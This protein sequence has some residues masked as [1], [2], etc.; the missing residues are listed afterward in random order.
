MTQLRAF[1]VDDEPL[2]LRRLIL[3]LGDIENVEIVGSSTSAK[4]AIGLIQKL[5]P[6]VV[7]LD[8]AMPSLDGFQVLERLDPAPAVVFVTAYDAH[9][10]R[11]FGVDAVDYLMKPV[12]P[13][14]LRRAVDRVRIAVEARTSASAMAAGDALPLPPGIDSPS[15]EE[16]LWA[17]R[18]REIVRVPVETI[19][20]IEAERD[21]VRLHSQEGGGLLRTTLAG[22]EAN[23]DPSL[24]IRVHRSAI[25]R[26]SAVTSLRRK[27]S[28]AL[29][30]SLAD[31]SEVPVG[32]R[33]ARGLRELLQQIR[34]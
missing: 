10:V 21:Y 9:A 20:W 23:L 3:T 26:R 19:E 32:R 29:V 27:R 30:I 2:A 17:Q 14:R 31:G 13:A 25:C 6:D 8:I 33:Y 15:Y 1:L 11:A 18:H 12:A 4:S 22:L 16:N 34:A 7:F 24:F 5:R 28:G